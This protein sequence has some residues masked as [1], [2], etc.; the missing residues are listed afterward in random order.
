M[1]I[2]LE[3]YRYVVAYLER[4]LN[5]YEF[6]DCL[7]SESGDPVESFEKIR[8]SLSSKEDF[9]NVTQIA[10]W[11]DKYLNA[12]QIKTMD[13]AA[14]Q[15][16]THQKRKRSMRTIR[17]HEDAHIML[18]E[19]AKKHNVSLSQCLELYLKE[20]YLKHLETTSKD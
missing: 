9:S 10:S 3:N 11:V 13:A 8:R 16:K 20:P 7:S 19:L 18:A 14:R 1:S 2:T 4:K 12:R 6:V 5:D 15:Y 17:V